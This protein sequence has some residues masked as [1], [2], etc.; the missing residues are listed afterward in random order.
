MLIHDARRSNDDGR[1][2][3]SDQCAVA[4]NRRH[5]I[6]AFHYLAKHNVQPIQLKERDENIRKVITTTQ[7]IG[8]FFI[9]YPWCLD[10]CDEELGAV[11]VF[12]SVC[13][14]KEKRLCMFYN[15]VLV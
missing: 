8:G 6:L 3:L 9:T 12:T 11:C 15:K 14:G 10:R 4:L 1:I 7:G 13:H 2:R 5:Y